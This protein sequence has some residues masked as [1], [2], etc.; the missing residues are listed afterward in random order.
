MDDQLTALLQA[1]AT[2][3][4]AVLATHPQPDRLR[5]AFETMV[6]A[7]P[8]PHETFQRTIATFRG[9]IP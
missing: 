8:Q 2:A 6:A 9:A 7:N 3:I 4:S 5:E 1:Y